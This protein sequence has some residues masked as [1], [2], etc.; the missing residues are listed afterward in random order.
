[1]LLIRGVPASVVQLFDDDDEAFAAVFLR[2]FLQV[3]QLQKVKEAAAQASP[4][5]R[6]MLCLS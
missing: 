6:S 3:P 4:A 5:E 1:M 2:V